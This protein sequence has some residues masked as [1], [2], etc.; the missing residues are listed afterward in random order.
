MPTHFK[1]TSKLIL[2]VSSLVATTVSCAESL[3]AP[4]PRD[5][6]WGAATAAYQIEGAW[7]VDGKGRS[8]WDDFCLNQGV[9]DNGDTGEV[10]DDY[11]HKYKEDIELMKGMG[12][13]HYRMSISWPRILPNG[14]ADNINAKGLAFYNDVIDTLIAAGIEPWI[15][16]YHWDL[17]ADL[18]D[19]TGHAGWLNSNITYLFN[20]YAEVCFKA[21][22]DRVKRWITINEP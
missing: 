13:K 14:R 19:K 22:G 6:A 20:D 10:A 4:F 8:I 11:Y 1:K 17:P 5:F 16:L 9:I 3:Y 18:D 2:L 12:L 21:F 15:T 7:N